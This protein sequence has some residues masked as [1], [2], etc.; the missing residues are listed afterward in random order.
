MRILGIDPGLEKSGVVLYDSGRRRVEYA[1][2]PA[3][4]EILRDVIPFYS[5]TAVHLAVEEMEPQGRFVGSD[6]FRTVAAA[7]RFIQ[8]WV[9]C[10]R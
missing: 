10:G 9:N 6:S 2:T 4:E 7:G 3:N 8:C 5:H 1:A